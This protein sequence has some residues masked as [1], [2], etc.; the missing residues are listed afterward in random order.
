M[1]DMA[2]RRNR[3]AVQNGRLI[4]RV[5]A[6]EGFAASR[7]LALAGPF[8]RVFAVNV[9]MFWPDPVAVFTGLAG[10]LAEG[11]RVQ[12][13]FQPR[14]GER[15]DAAAIAGADKIGDAM[16]AAGLTAIR[17]EKLSELSPLVVCVIGS[18]A[19]G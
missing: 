5:G 6:V 14:T 15:T 4:L 13:T 2:A 7:D 18:N 17:V 8:D 10:R 1:R 16:R 9:A 3:G 11:G 12:I 19:G